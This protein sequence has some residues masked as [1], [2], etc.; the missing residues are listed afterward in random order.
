MYFMAAA[1]KSKPNQRILTKLMILKVIKNKAHK[2]SVE[3]NWQATQIIAQIT[4]PRRSLGR[5]QHAC[6]GY[7]CPSTRAHVLD[8]PDRYIGILINSARPVHVYVH[9]YVVEYC[10]TCIDDM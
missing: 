8:Y 4:T 9:V 2:R 3:I 10:N 1:R 7:V 5:L 6:T